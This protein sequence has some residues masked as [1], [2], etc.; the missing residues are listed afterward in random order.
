MPSFPDLPLPLIIRAVGALQLCILIASAMVPGQLDWKE[1]LGKLPPL[2]RQMFWTYGIYTAAAILSLG[3]FSLLASDDLA[4]GGRLARLVCGANC[5]FWGAR[6]ALQGVFD[7]KPFLTR[8]W[9]T[10]GYHLLTVLFLLFTAFYGWLT[11]R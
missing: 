5:L 3:L 2:L 10:A 1:S 6:L 8:W 4:A 11:F 7:A 9:L